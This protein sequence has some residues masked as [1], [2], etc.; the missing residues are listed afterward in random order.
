MHPRTMPPM[1]WLPTSI[2]DWGVPL[3]IITGV[4][5]GAG[6]L[7]GQSYLNHP[8][9]RLY[10]QLA[11]VGLFIFSQMALAIALPF[12]D[13][14]Q[15]QLLT[16]FGYALTAVI[17]LSSTSFVSNAM[18]GLMLKAMGTFKT[19]DFIQVLDQFGRVTAK[20][21]L[22]TEIQSED[23]DAIALP[24]MFV[25]SNPV[26]IVDQSGT[27]VSAEIGIGYD[28]HRRK[29]RE[30]LLVA[31]E[32][33]GLTDPFVQILD[34][35]DFAVRYR[36]T[37]FLTDVGK[38]VSMRS[39]LKAQ[40]LDTLHNGGVEIMTPS[41]M[42][43]RPL[44]PEK[45]V[46]PVEQVT[47]EDD[48]DHGKAERMMFD[49]ADLAARIE[50]FREHARTLGA[51]IKELEDQ[52]LVRT[53]ALE[54]VGRM[55]GKLWGRAPFLSL[56]LTLV[57]GAFLSAFVNNTPIV[58]LLLPILISVCLRNKSSPAKVLMPMGFATLL[59][60]MATTI[61]TSTNLLVVNVAADLGLEAFG[62]FDFALPASIAACVG[63]VYL[64]LI[65]PLL[66]P[67]RESK[68]LDPSP[69]LFN[70]RLLLKENS[71]VLG[72]TL[73][74]AIALTGGDMK[75]VRVRRGETM[76]MP[77][78]DVVLKVG[79]RLRVQDT[80]S[81]LKKFEE[82]LKAEL[83]SGDTRVDDEHPLAGDNQT[84]AEIAVVQGSSLD[85][86]NLSY[87]RF[88][89]RYQLAVLA[90]HR[91]GKDVWRATEEIHEVILQP[92]DV[93]LVQGPKEQL[94]LLKRSTEF[95][96]LDSS[97]DLPSSARA[98][99]ALGILATV[100]AIAALGI[101][102]IAI[103]AVAGCAAMLLTRCLSIGES[104][105]AISP[106]VYFVV[107]ASLA[108]GMALQV[109][110]ATVYLTE[111][112][113]YVT[114][115]SPPIVVLSALMLLLAVLTNIVSNNAAAVIGTP[116]A[117]GIAQAL[118]LPAEPFVL[119]V[120][121]GA[122]MSYAT[123][124][125]Y[126]TNLL[127]MSAG[128]YTFREFVKV[129]ADTE[130]DSANPFQPNILLLVAED[131]SP[132][133]GS[134]GDALAK[135][136]N[137]DQL[138]A[139]G[140]RYTNVFTTAGVC[141]PSR[142]A[143]ITGQHQISFGGQHMRTTTGPLG[144]YLAQPAAGVRAFPE[145]LRAAG[146]YTYTDQ[147]LDYQFSSV[148]AGSGPFTIWDEDG[149]VPTAWRNRAP[150]QPFFALINFLETH[151]SGVMQATGP[152]HSP[153]H[154]ATQKM[155]QARGLV[156]PAITDP[157]EVVLPPYY[158]DLPEVRADMARHYDNIHAMDRRVGEILAALEA[159]GLKNDTLIVWTTDHGDGL[160]RAKRELFDSGT[161]VP[162]VLH[163]PAALAATTATEPPTRNDTVDHRLVSFVDLA[164][165]LLAFAG[166]TAPPYL[167]GENFLTSNR[168][169]VYASRD[170]IDEIMD[171]QRSIRSDRYKYIKSWYPDVAGGHPLNY[172]DNLDMVRVWRK[173]WQAGTLPAVQF[174]WFK[175]AGAEQLYDIVADPHELTN[176]ASSTDH[177]T[178]LRD[179]RSAL[180]TFLAEIGDT[181][182]IPEAE[183]RAMYLQD[184]ALPQTPPPSVVIKNGILI[185]TSEND[186]SIGYRLSSAERTA[187]VKQETKSRR[188]TKK[189]RIGRSLFT[190][191]VIA[192]KPRS[193]LPVLNPNG[194]IMSEV[195]SNNPRAN[196]GD[197]FTRS[198]EELL[199]EWAI[200]T[201]VDPATIP[202]SELNPGHPDLFED[203]RQM[204][205]FGRLREQD[206]V[207]YTEVSQFGP[208]WSVTKFE[209]IMY[210]DSHHNLFSSDF[211]KG[212]IS[213]GGV[214]QPE[215]A[216]DF[217]LPMFIQEDPPK[218]DQQRKV[219]A[220]MFTPSK[221]AGLEDLIRK[222][223]CAIL[224]NLPRNKEFNW[225]KEVSVELTGQM[226]A[227]LFNVPQEDRH[228][229]IYW[230]DAVQ[231]LGNPEFFATIEE[232]FGELWKCYEYFAAVWQERLAQNEPGDDLISMLVHGE[233]TRDM[234]PN[235]YLG[236]ILLLIVGGNDT[237][238][239]SISGGVLA[240]NQ[241]PEQYNKLRA[242][243][244]LINTMVPEI[245]RWQ[246]PV[247]HMARTALT[248]TELGGKQIKEGD[249][250]VMW[251]LSGNRDGDAIENPDEFIIVIALARCSCV[252]C[253]KR[254]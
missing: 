109:T 188:R 212:G 8:N 124:M 113:L 224:D 45:P 136:P 209:D 162:L 191:A 103:T 202:L 231:N 70:A 3:L 153:A 178:I 54:P 51:E 172:R 225:V 61:G 205:Y 97:I 74:E 173:A 6:W 23:R 60:G 194:D 65:A 13:A 216:D 94:S 156:A 121:F 67:E 207:H 174:R 213:L 190:A 187:Q 55:L 195:D 95:M 118:Q 64:W 235:E 88:L 206:P 182:A 9:N 83:Y 250:V 232:G 112:F 236:N 22:H 11:F 198:N 161:K 226:L 66:L 24:N 253:G 246:S 237:T 184:G 43:Q 176:L 33:A 159:D 245:I 149:A 81:N 122:N 242:D 131:L 227:T 137:I 50:R 69:R 215:G 114:A 199:A 73:G 98:P 166:V 32:A 230:S 155:R 42:N 38:L 1:E 39:D 223:A 125:A 249:R 239:N 204:P 115:G 228:K 214:A 142:A 16:L 80:P 117:V 86:A 208:Y 85:R 82:A 34:I 96:V 171:R 78:P 29:V 132:R 158:P 7:L 76:V 12:D 185:L 143:L 111:V 183:L 27:L 221:L 100:V 35:G 252:C 151:E 164:P 19:G 147:K 189:L 248:D 18:A 144:P 30:L 104:L 243:H 222:R 180:D 254:S 141:A 193:E 201:S 196:R 240:L 146:Y 93:L 133:I 25:I 31:A 186:A 167:H 106:S 135:T 4:T 130:T 17:A 200:D 157:A 72:K 107:A 52:G 148:Y 145:L 169:Y 62:L 244:N 197:I 123:P 59:G 91:A 139:Q 21:L 168:T 160:P 152:A 5:A 48:S 46:V 40:I 116:I 53:G 15:S 101:M 110:G 150:G 179:M 105:R 128:N 163:V 14:T 247:A 58:V 102:P 68:L 119:A 211:R 26:K 229:L 71:L 134:F 90:L 20:A 217:D 87:A 238:R 44:D 126:K 170:R 241:F 165:T 56:L 129:G 36:V 234:P 120:L 28:T 203:A 47:S 181:G 92:G 57:V 37:G 10:R 219:V 251:Y 220:P 79:D 41:V 154:A 63:V 99:L 210:V 175:P 49:R 89:D 233:A 177:Q 218:H 140:T 77:L 138:A 2:I 192:V 127:V 84:L 75:V 108:L